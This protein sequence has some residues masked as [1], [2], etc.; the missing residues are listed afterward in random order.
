LFLPLLAFTALYFLLNSWLV[1]IAVGLENGKSPVRL[2]WGNFAWLSVNYFSGASV[3]A[4]IVTYTR[5]LEISTLAVIVPLLVVSYLTFRTA[6]GR[7]EDS[8]NHLAELN[9]L[10][11][12]TIETLAMAIDA[13]DQ[14][15]HGH[16]RRVQAYAVGLAKRIGVVD[17]GLLK[18]IEA[19]A[20]LHDMGKL[21]VPEYILNKPGKLTIAEFEKMKLHA[22]VG[23]DILCAIEFPYPVVPIVRHHHESWDGTGYPHGLKGT[24]IPIGARILA[25]VDCFDALTSDRPYRPRLSNGDALKILLERRGSMYDP[26]IIDT[27]VQVYEEI[28]PEQTIAAPTRSALNEITSSI[29]SRELQGPPTRLST[30]GSSA[31]E[32]LTIYSLSTALAGHASVS[33]TGDIVAKHLRR[34]V[35]FSLSIVYMY[36][37]ERDEL[38]AKHA[39]GD[40]SS[41]VMDVR[42]DTGARLS[43]WVAAHRQTIINSDAELD[44]GDVAR[45]SAPRLRSCLSTPLVSNGAL[46]GVLSLYSTAEMF[47]D[48]HRKVVEGVAHH[49]AHTF[50]RAAEFDRSSKRDEVT[51]LPSLDNLKQLLQGI[52]PQSIASSPMSLLFLNVV[53]VAEANVLHG[54]PVDDQAVRQVVRR[55]QECLEIT[56]VLFR[57]GDD[58]FVALLN[59]SDV[60]GAM[61]IGQKVREHVRSRAV[62]PG[63]LDGVQLEVDVYATN[64]P[65]NVALLREF[66]ATR[67]LNASTASHAVAR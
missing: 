5:E 11:L 25:I 66:I 34:L 56:D 36:D 52:D 46:V 57:C 64:V 65:G 48:D 19:A 9:R 8:Y 37:D 15:T 38:V 3:A 32:M 16:I 6:M 42:I 40:A 59:G 17:E 58:E 21:A 62:S 35:P 45:T 53:S 14:I 60:D 4:L 23:A 22:T 33:D 61:A 30:P 27:F 31:D 1:A 43:G 28:A 2:W 54:R 7:A 41:L 47:T 10:H 51:G 20:L 13:K 55:V 24:D 50:R 26:L 44:L 29:V 63:L 18:A 67:R 39:L 49:I 12:S